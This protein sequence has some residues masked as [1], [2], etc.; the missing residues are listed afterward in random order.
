[1]LSDHS[2]QTDDALWSFQTNWWI[3]LTISN[4]LMDALWSFQTNWCI[5]FDL[6]FM[7][8]LRSSQTNLCWFT[9]MEKKKTTMFLFLFI[10]YKFMLV[11]PQLE[12]TMFF[13]HHIQGLLALLIIWNKIMLLYYHMEQIMFLFS[14]SQTKWKSFLSYQLSQKKKNHLISNSLN[15]LML[16]S[17][18]RQQI[19]FLFFSSS[20]RNWCF[21]FSWT[22]YFH[23]CISQTEVA[24]S[25][26]GT[27]NVSFFFI[28][29]IV[30]TTDVTF[31]LKLCFL[32]SHGT[33][34]SSCQI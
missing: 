17:H 7:D 30:S 18:H 31:C 20:Q 34:F 32:P 25:S 19:I 10:S 27:N 3:S 15:Q 14:L 8:T 12:Q 16:L 4:K 9:W 29:L 22:T 1:M 28:I 33:F 5:L 21:F 13:F 24:L 26:F 6:N 2:K 23:F 11:Y